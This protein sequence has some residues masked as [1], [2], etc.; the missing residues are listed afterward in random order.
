MN[1]TYRS[2]GDH[3]E[4]LEIDYDPEKITFRKILDVFWENHNPLRSSFGSRQYM[5]ILLYHDNK[6]KEMALKTKK[7]WKQTLNGEIQTEIAPFSDF[8]IAE[9]YHQKYYLRRR[10]TIID[11]LNKLCPTQEAF[12]NSTLPARLNGFVHGYGSLEG[13][14]KEI[15]EDWGLSPSDEQAIFNVL[16]SIPNHP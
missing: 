10:R 1:P 3:T 2:M 11:A 16:N 5:S 14:K 15:K 13:I 6:Q 9:D 4:T 7:Q 8:Y 12:V